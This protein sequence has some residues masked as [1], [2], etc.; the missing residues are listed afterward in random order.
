M[1]LI[2]LFNKWEW[3]VLAKLQGYH[4]KDS[5]NYLG[6]ICDLFLTTQEKGVAADC[7][8]REK[9][10]KKVLRSVAYLASPSIS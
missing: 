9:R 2:P 5:N 10:K 4:G 8:K 1:K 6:K 3:K 7:A